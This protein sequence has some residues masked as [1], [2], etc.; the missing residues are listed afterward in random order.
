PQGCQLSASERLVGFGQRATAGE[1]SSER[2]GQ[3]VARG[4]LRA[5]AWGGALRSPLVVGHTSRPAAKQTV[6]DASPPNTIRIAASSIFPR[7]LPERRLD[8]RLVAL[9]D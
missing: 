4:N 5:T 7:F 3:T 2:A 9:G 6:C 8:F 1:P